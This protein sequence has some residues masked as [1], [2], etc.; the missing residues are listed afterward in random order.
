MPVNWP[1][2]D[3]G[4]ARLIQGAAELLAPAAPI[5]APPVQDATP[6]IR[7]ATAAQTDL[8]ARAFAYAA[9]ISYMARG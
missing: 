5:P 3:Y 8:A 7:A 9:A 6:P 2:P 1:P 4:P